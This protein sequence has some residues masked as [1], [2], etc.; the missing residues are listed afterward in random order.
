LVCVAI[1]ADFDARLDLT[2]AAR[3]Q[4]AIVETGIGLLDV[5]V[6][7][8]LNTRLNQTISAGGCGAVI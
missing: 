7:A 4:A 1:I 6:I 8:S 2:V 3:R 5:G